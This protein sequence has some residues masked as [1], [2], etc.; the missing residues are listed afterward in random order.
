MC[1]ALLEIMEPEINKIKEA[2][3]EKTTISVKENEI[4]CA[5]K[6]SRDLGASDGQIRDVL[7]KNHQLSSAEADKYLFPMEGSKKG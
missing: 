7:I 1:Q 2:A 6:I 3:V 4:L 5:V